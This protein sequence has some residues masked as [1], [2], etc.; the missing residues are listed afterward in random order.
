MWPWSLI[1]DAEARLSRGMP[2]APDYTELIAAL[3]GSASQ[4]IEDYCNN[5]F[6][7]RTVVENVNWERIAG[8]NVIALRKYPIVTVFSIEDQVARTIPADWYWIDAEKGFLVTA[9]GWTVPQNARGFAT[10][11][12]VKYCAG[13][14]ADTS[15]V[16]PVLKHACRLVVEDQ[17]F[18]GA[19]DSVKRNVGDFSIE[20][21]RTFQTLGGTGQDSISL[22]EVCKTLLGPY[23]SRMV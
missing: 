16:D 13:R 21:N 23:I 10:Y 1:T 8:R 5:V 12:T 9:G 6:V 7:Q 11:W 2:V 18:G 19:G 15:S 3:I 20:Y 22:P 14:Y 4:A 17:F